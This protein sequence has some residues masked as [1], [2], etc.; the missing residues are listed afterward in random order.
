MFQGKQ[1]VST[2]VTNQGDPKLEDF[3]NLWV[4]KHEKKIYNI[5]PPLDLKNI[6]KKLTLH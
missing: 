5:G 2:W 4:T 1:M 3:A 6:F